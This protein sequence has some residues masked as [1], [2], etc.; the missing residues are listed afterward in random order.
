[1]ELLLN[2]ISFNYLAKY[3][4]QSIVIKECHKNTIYGIKLTLSRNAGAYGCN[5]KI[6]INDACA[7]DGSKTV[8]FSTF[9]AS[10]KKG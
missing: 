8:F 4:L 2:E 5:S 3:M 9:N 6:K 10:I 1:M 7:T